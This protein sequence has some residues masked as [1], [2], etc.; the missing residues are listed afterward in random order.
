MN[1][2]P[3]TI[4]IADDDYGDRKHLKRVMK[5]VHLS[6]T[7]EEAGDMHDALQLC[8]EKAF[9]FAFLDYQMPGNTDLE[10]ISILHHRHPYTSI[11][12]MTGQGDEEVASKAI[13][14]GAVDYVPKR[15]ISADS[16]RRIVEYAQKQTAMQKKLDDQRESLEH[17]SHVLVHDLSAP[18]RHI[19]WYSEIIARAVQ[20]EDY[21]DLLDHCRRISQATTRMQD[22]ISTLNIY[23]TV[24][25]TRVTFEECSMEEVAD[26]V[27]TMLGNSISERNAAVTFDALPTV[28]GNMPQLVQLLQNLVANGIKFCDAPTP[29]VHISAKKRDSDCC[30]SVADNG[31]GIDPKFYKSIFS[32]FKRLHGAGSSKYP[33]S[34]LGLSTCKKIVDR[35]EGEIWCDSEPGQGTTFYVTLPLA[36]AFEQV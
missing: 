19:S 16:I 20:K 27:I 13:K 9:D 21:Q 23:N 4:L 7:I 12:L 14:L 25:T 17:F 33:G 26:E 2:K 32:P 1:I 18:I 30:I 29:K 36:T 3:L 8:T 11:V 31:I 10:G 28:Y 15:S 34:G 6:C 35:H 24:D 5:Q 22:L